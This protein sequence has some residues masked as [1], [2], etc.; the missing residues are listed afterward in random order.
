M[1]DMEKAL[2]CCCEDQTR[3]GVKDVGVD[4]VADRNLLAYFS[5]IGIHDNQHLGIAPSNEEPAMFTVHGDG[6][7]RSGGSHWPARLD[8]ELASI[9][10][11]DLICTF[12]VVINHPFAVH[13]GLFGSAAQWEGL[14][15]GLLF[16]I[17]HRRILA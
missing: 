3:R 6:D 1:E 8:R 9:D 11:H 13:D 10:C 15:N 7:R 2:T 14:Y 16:G 12:D 5:G 4:T 17:D